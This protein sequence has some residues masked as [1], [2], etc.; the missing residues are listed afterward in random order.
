MIVERTLRVLVLLVAAGGC[1][2]S[3]GSTSTP[4][5]APMIMYERFVSTTWSLS[6]IGGASQL[7]ITDAAGAAACALSVDQKRTLGGAGVEII[8]QLAGPVTDTCPAG[9]YS[10]NGKC[11]ATFGTDAYVPAGCAFYRKWDAQGALVGFTVAINGE[12]TIVG[13]PDS[14]TIRASVGFL[15]ASFDEVFTMTNGAGAQPW[16]MGS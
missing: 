2:P 15:G 7:T 13:T 3:G 4:D 8:L 10:I 16:C 9:H 11:P 1:M 6:T 14:C 12:I 5:A